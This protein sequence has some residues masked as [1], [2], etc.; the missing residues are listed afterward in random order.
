MA[1]NRF[2]SSG[3]KESEEI[4][5]EVGS[6]DESIKESLEGSGVNNKL[7]TQNAYED[8]KAMQFKKALE[9]STALGNLLTQID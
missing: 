8:F 5:D 3:I 6:I 9:D 4:L 2:T 7:F 1:S